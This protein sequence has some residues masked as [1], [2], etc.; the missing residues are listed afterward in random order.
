MQKRYVILI[1]CL[2]ALVGIAVAAV[3]MVMLLVGA[4]QMYQ[5]LQETVALRDYVVQLQE[6]NAQLKDTYAAGYDLEEIRDIAQTMGMIPAES[7]P[8][9]RIEVTVPEAPVQPSAWESFWQFFVEM[10]A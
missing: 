6:K 3:L 8:H 9:L 5:T 2:V 7:A 4:V 1:A 10:F